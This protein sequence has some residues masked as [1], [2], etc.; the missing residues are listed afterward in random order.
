MQV[1]EAAKK[2]LFTAFGMDLLSTQ[3]GINVFVRIL[4]SKKSQVMPMFG[5]HK[6]FI[7]K[8]LSQHIQRRDQFALNKIILMEEN[9]KTLFTAIRHTVTEFVAEVSRLDISRINLDDELVHYGFDSIAFTGLS[10]HLNTYYQTTL[11]PALFYQYPTI[12]KV[13]EYLLENCTVAIMSKHGE[14]VSDKLDMFNKN[15][16]FLLAASLGGYAKEEETHAI[17]AKSQPSTLAISKPTDGIAIIGMAG[18]FP[19]AADVNSLWSNLMQGYDA[20]THFP[21]ERM[22]LNPAK[23]WI[24]WGGFIKDIDKF[25][26]DFFNISP[27]E[28]EMM[29]PQ[30]RIFLMTACKSIED[31]GYSI[32]AF[33]GKHCAL[34]VGVQLQEYGKLIEQHFEYDSYVGTGN[35]HSILVNR[36]SYLLNLVGLVKRLIRHVLSS[37]VAIHRA[38]QSI[39]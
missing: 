29:D 3:A 17:V 39:R 27:R 2:M 7:Q 26:A 12:N 8:L 4:Q 20:I 14:V 18:I 10:N 6:R 19:G 5:D 21:D 15:S 11:T 25:D 28:A 36:V 32:E 23:S 37:L 31:A 1:S 24:D 22:E 30:Q 35:S 34:F 16:S 13:A 33:S 38:V 9:K